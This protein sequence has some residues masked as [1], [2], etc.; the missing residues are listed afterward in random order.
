LTLTISEIEPDQPS[1]A[2]NIK[3]V[4]PTTMTTIEGNSG[5]V[6]FIAQD[7]RTNQRYKSNG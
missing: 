1:S 6:T 5:S 7:E 2:D 4:G 3:I